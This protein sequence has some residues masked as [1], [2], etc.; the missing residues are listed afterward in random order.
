MK[1]QSVE[2]QHKI[3]S[4]VVQNSETIKDVIF[5]INVEL[6]INSLLSESNFPRQKLIQSDIVWVSPVTNHSFSIFFETTSHTYCVDVS[7]NS[8]SYNKSHR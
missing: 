4:K 2:K 6:P 5:G 1:I 7:N 3:V 8:I